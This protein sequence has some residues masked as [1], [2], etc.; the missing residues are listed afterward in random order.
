M[1]DVPKFD[2]TEDLDIP[3]FDDTEPVSFDDTEPMDEPA[4]ADKVPEKLPDS[5]FTGAIGSPSDKDMLKAL[6][7]VPQTVPDALANLREGVPGAGWVKK[8]AAAFKA[9]LDKLRGSDKSFEE[10]YDKWTAA[11]NKTKAE[12]VARNPDAARAGEMM[13][14]MTGPSTA[15]LKF[16]QRVMVDAGMSAAD[17]AGRSAELK[18]SFDEAVK[19]G[20]ISAGINLLGGMLAKGGKAVGGLDKFAEERAVKS[21]DPILSQQE[22]L[23]NKGAVRKLGREML[24]NDIVKFGSSVDDIAD[25]LGNVL[26]R[27]G[28]EIQGIRTAADAA[29]ASTD[30]NR[31]ARKGSAMEAFSDA[32]NESA[33]D[34]A[35]VYARNADRFAKVPTRSIAET[36]EE[37]ADLSSKINFKRPADAIPPAQQEAYRSLRRDM[38][39]Q[40]TDQVRQTRPQDLNKYQDLMERFA[41]FKD[42][43]EIVQKAVAR[44]AKNADLGLRGSILAS[45]AARGEGAEGLARG[46]SVAMLEKLAKE[47]GN[48]ALA[49]GAD[50]AA[51]LLAKPNM[52]GQYA[53]VLTDAANKGSANFML[54]HSMLMKDDPK[55]K[56]LVESQESVP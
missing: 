45:Q 28:R 31:L 1:A 48:S 8:G 5:A 26:R 49:V 10:E 11:E 19:A 40:V 23:A 35:K 54:V 7:G 29:G 6:K 2:D 50:K 4:P 47:R 14:A 46:L 13:G 27:D 16:M 38:V 21:L 25:D 42:G 51:K 52:L 9:G 3:S 15:S 53:K 37:I 30:L 12:R 44:N 33:E 41:L 56:E 17:A 34:M 20:G 32:T 22:R 24:D 39:D 18:D 36:Q 55:Y 43:D